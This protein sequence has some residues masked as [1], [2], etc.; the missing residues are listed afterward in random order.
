MLT[1]TKLDYFDK[2]PRYYH[3]TFANLD[4]KPFFARGAIP[5]VHNSLTYALWYLDWITRLERSGDFPSL[6]VYELVR[7]ERYLVPLGDGTYSVSEIDTI[8]YDDRMAATLADVPELFRKKWHWGG[9]LTYIPARCLLRVSAQTIR[10][11]V[12]LNEWLDLCRS[13][14]SKYLLRGM[15]SSL[16][17]TSE[18]PSMAAS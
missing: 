11:T 5:T 10:Q 9:R 2:L 1:K 16:K 7:A 12:D 17:L 3:A 6:Y 13:L 4:N 15:Y 14:D 18:L 8:P